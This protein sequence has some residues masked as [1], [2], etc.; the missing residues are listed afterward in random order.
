MREEKGEKMSIVI[1]GIQISSTVVS[2]V[3]LVEK[4]LEYSISSV[5][6]EKHD[7]TFNV[8]WIQV[9]LNSNEGIGYHRSS[10]LVQEIWGIQLKIVLINA[11]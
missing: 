6:E 5:K 9:S 1:T 7:K 3:T 8:T 10:S 2:P 11:N 4:A